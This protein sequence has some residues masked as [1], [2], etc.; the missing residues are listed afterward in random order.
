MSF[1]FP[2]PVVVIALISIY[3]DHEIYNDFSSNETDPHFAPA[4]E[5]FVSYLGAVNPSSSSS[6]TSSSSESENYFDFQHGDSAFFIFD[7]RKY[8]SSNTLLDTVE[9]EK[10]MLGSKQ[11]EIFKTWCQ[12]VNETVTWKF[13]VSSTPMMTLWSHGDDTWSGFQRER[14]ELLDVMEFMG[15][16]IVLSGVSF[17]FRFFFLSS[18]LPLDFI[19]DDLGYGTDCTSRIDMNLQ[20]L[21]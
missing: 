17:F 15:N 16:V 5:A 6:S 12:N 14:E 21:H 2:F 13:I 19:T 10:T 7:T 4:N 3:D 11:K 1:F 9:N 18:F 20:L 8:R